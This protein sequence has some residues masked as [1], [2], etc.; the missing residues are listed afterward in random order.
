MPEAR[1][2]A[3]LVRPE[4]EARG[5]RVFEVSAVTRA[6][7][8]ELSFALAD[9]VQADRAAKAA[10]PA[11]QRIVIRPRAVDEREFTVRVDGG[12]YGDT[13][14][15]L[16]AKPERWV[17][18]TDFDNEEAV[19]FLADRLA[20]LGVEEELFAAGA[21]PGSS[22]TIAGREFDWE[23]TLSSAAELITSPR[24]TDARFADH[25]RET[26]KKRRETYLERMDAK[27]AARAELEAERAAGLWVDDEGFAV[28][29]EH[30]E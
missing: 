15:I 12:S 14:T 18:Q 25:T 24:G 6:G 28:D 27:A 2:L 21:V 13:Y 5:Y 17:M 1:E 16:G 20:K 26:R 10:V 4:L 8:R 29:T 7:L 23:P 3:A 19:G 30:G 9:L 11:K 22:V